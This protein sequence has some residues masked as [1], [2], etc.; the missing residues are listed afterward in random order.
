MFFTIIFFKRVRLLFFTYTPTPPS[1]L[2]SQFLEIKIIAHYHMK[3]C[4]RCI[5]ID[6]SFSTKK[7]Q[8][9][10]KHEGNVVDGKLYIRT[11]S[12]FRCS[13]FN[14][15]VL[16]NLSKQGVQYSASFQEYKQLIATTAWPLAMTTFHFFFHIKRLHQSIQLQNFNYF[17]ATIIEFIV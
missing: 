14:P 11:F 1:K 12:T 9:V 17:I 16:N 2:F 13:S 8:L 5:L 10:D 15:I 6:M 7:Y 3:A 4:I